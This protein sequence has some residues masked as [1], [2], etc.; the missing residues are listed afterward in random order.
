MSPP[1]LLARSP[2]VAAFLWPRIAG[3]RFVGRQARLRSLDTRPEEMGA[4]RDERT[5]NII[6]DSCTA[7][8]GAIR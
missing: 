8:E 6:F 5:R 7:S 3:Q 2:R 1:N 4:T